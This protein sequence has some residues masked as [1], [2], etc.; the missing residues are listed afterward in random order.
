MRFAQDAHVM[1]WIS[2]TIPASTGSWTVSFDM[3]S[4]Q[5]RR[6]VPGL[7]DRGE[8]R[9]VVERLRGGDDESPGLRADLDILDAWNPADFFADGQLAVAACHP[10]DLV[11]RGG[12][13]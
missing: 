3:T 8:D 9:R 13:H 2:R 4:S 7:V 10:G 11:L 5:S 6:G 1:P 12:R